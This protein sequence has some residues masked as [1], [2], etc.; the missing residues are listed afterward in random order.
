V[1]GEARLAGVMG[2][3]IGHSRSPLLHGFWL[4]RYGIDGAYVKLPVRPGDAP[5]ALRAL[6]LLGFA[7]CNV[8]APHKQAALAAMDRVDDVVRRIG[9][10]NTVIVR[11]DGSLEGRNTDAFGFMAHLAQ[12]APGFSAKSGP[13]VVV[14]AGGAARAIV[15]ALIDAGAPEIRVVNRTR[16]RADALARE[17]GRPLTAVEWNARE[18][19]LADTALLVQTTTL[20]MQGQPPLDLALDRL[21]ASAVVDDIVYAPL[22]TRLLAAARAR[23]NRVVDGLGM[24]LHQGRPGFAAWFGVD[25]EVTQELADFVAADVKAK[26]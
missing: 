2:W 8:T 23:G 12:S 3:P 13:A 9:A 24:L 16:E 5:A 22:E 14:G 26:A 15:V 10:V 17:F 11:D 19:A 1:S 7:G 25:P 18:A 6:R 4:E 20:G 21:P